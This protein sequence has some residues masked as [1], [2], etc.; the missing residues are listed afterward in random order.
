MVYRGSK[1]AVRHTALDSYYIKKFCNNLKTKQS[2]NFVNTSK[3]LLK[4]ILKVALKAV[5]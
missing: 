2:Y 5:I 3:K 1:I 4:K